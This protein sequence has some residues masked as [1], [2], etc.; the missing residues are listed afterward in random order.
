MRLLWIKWRLW[1]GH[2]AADFGRRI[3]I[4]AWADEFELA[5]DEF[6]AD[7]D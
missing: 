4:G 7:D 2:W 1:F 3:E 5:P 6:E